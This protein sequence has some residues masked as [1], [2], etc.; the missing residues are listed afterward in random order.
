VTNF[1]LKREQG[2]QVPEVEGK[3][4]SGS[5]IFRGP[6]ME[7]IKILLMVNL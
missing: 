5:F 6:S 2:I 4:P 7:M 1:I 3:P